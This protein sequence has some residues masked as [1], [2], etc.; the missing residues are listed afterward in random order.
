MTEML[1]FE[2]FALYRIPPLECF[3]S[4]F[5][6]LLVR[7]PDSESFVLYPMPLLECFPSAFFVLSLGCPNFEPFALYP[8]TH[9]E[10]FDF[11]PITHLECFASVFFGLQVRCAEKHEGV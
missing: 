2:L 1:E 9:L 3:S 5:L 6:A 7:S 8:I 11:Y 10:C 4:A